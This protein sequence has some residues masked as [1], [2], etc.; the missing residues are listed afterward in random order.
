MYGSCFSFLLKISHILKTDVISH[1]E[2]GLLLR[3]SANLKHIIYSVR[4]LTSKYII[5]YNCYIITE[6]KV[7]S[8]VL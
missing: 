1:F 6:F 5:S 2:K 4:R 8:M 3:F 7:V